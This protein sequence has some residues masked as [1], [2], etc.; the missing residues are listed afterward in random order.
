MSG[1]SKSVWYGAHRLGV[2]GDWNRCSHNVLAKTRWS[3]E[4]SNLRESEDGASD[5][6][7]KPEGRD[8]LFFCLLFVAVMFWWWEKH[9]YPSHLLGKGHVWRS[10]FSTHTAR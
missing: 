2:D 8:E 1:A 5:E 3:W 4:V 7:G 10:L 6:M 9:L